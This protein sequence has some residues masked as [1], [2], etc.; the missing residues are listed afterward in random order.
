MRGFTNADAVPVKTDDLAHEARW[1]G[2]QLSA[3]PP[4]RYLLHV[5]L[6][7]ADIFAVTLK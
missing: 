1:K 2:K 5:H 7:K 4:G 3:L 6:E